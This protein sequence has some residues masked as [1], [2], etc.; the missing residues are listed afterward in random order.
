MPSTNVFSLEIYFKDGDYLYFFAAHL[1]QITATSLFPYP[2]FKEFYGIFFPFCL[3]L[4]STSVDE[5]FLY[6]VKCTLI[7]PSEHHLR[8][9]YIVRH[10]SINE[11]HQME[12]KWYNFSTT[13]KDPFLSGV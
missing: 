7:L 12:L 2:F 11:L 13:L 3:F 4:I 9:I 8:A 6:S 5:K 1:E 10:A